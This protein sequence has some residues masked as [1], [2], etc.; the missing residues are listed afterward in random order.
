MFNLHNDIWWLVL[1]FKIKVPKLKVSWRYIS[2]RTVTQASSYRKSRTMTLRIYCRPLLPILV[3]VDSHLKALIE[4]FSKEISTLKS[5]KIEN[6]DWIL[7]DRLVEYVD[8]ITIYAAPFTIRHQILYFNVR[9]TMTQ[10]RLC[11]GHVDHSILGTAVLHLGHLTS[12][13]LHLLDTCV[14]NNRMVEWSK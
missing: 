5:D 1:N 8:S 4:K 7:D 2:V 14:L 9:P 13:C 6:D 11:V 12:L 3:N 10:I